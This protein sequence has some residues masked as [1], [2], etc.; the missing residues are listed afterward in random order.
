MLNTMRNPRMIDVRQPA[1]FS[2][3][4]I[5][6]SELVPLRRLSR[7]CEDWDRKQP[8]TLV[9]RSG[10]RAQVAYRQ[11]SSRGFANVT[12]LPGGIMKWRAA[13]KPLQKVPQTVG[14]RIRT[15]GSR[16]VVVGAAVAL[17]HFVSVWFLAIP[18]VMAVR[19]FTIG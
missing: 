6:G 18:A 16:L 10:H 19:W 4:H 7:A 8:I 3:G 13:G 17:A 11:L 1:E 15:W 2:A 12:V 5:E 14:M 9:C